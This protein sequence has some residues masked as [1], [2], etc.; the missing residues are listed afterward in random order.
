MKEVLRNAITEAFHEAG[1][2]MRARD[3][4]AAYRW[5][6]RAHILTQRMPLA[7]AKSHWL[8]LTLGWITK[9]WREV[10]GQ[11]PWIVAALLFS[12]IW[13]PFGNT[14]RARVSAFS[15]MPLSADLEELLRKD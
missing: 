8:M 7:H 5:T 6:E 14:G 2:A 3:F 1:L 13:V 15:V 10:V 4:Q 12:R 9:D 11:L